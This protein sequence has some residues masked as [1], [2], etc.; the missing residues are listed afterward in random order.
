MPAAIDNA[1]AAVAAVCMCEGCKP[2]TIS[3]HCRERGTRYLSRRRGGRFV[4]CPSC[5]Q[6]YQDAGYMVLDIPFDL[7]PT[8]TQDMLPD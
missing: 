7:L 3:G 5:G 2:G 1:V 4:L 8:Y 6:A